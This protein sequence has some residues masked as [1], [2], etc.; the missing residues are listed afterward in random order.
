MH[1]IST[2]ICLILLFQKKMWLIIGGLGGQEGG[3]KQKRVGGIYK[4]F[5]WSFEKWVLIN[6][7]RANGLQFFL[8][9]HIA[10][11][12]WVK[13]NMKHGEGIMLIRTVVRKVTNNEKKQKN[14]LTHHE[15]TDWIAKQ[16]ESVKSVQ[17]IKIV[18]SPDISHVLFHLN[19]LKNVL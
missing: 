16:T 7:N 14:K 2:P 9:I 3:L 10:P 15:I 13:S 12:H 17:R 1:V 19:S 4:N 5:N 11:T 8:K 6:E 18:D